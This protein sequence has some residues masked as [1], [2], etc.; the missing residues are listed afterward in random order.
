MYWRMKLKKFKWH[1]F[2]LLQFFF[3]FE[4]NFVFFVEFLK[5][6]SVLIA[7]TIQPNLLETMQKKR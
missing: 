1:Y 3:Y 4:L 7:M 5:K 6:K 2:I